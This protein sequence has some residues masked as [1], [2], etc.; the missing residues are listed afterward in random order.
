MGKCSYYQ[1]K[2]SPIYKDNE[3]THTKEQSGDLSLEFILKILKKI[4]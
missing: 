3:S 1:K 2:M 4:K